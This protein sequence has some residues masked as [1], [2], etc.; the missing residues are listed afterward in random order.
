MNTNKFHVVTGRHYTLNSFRENRFVPVCYHCAK[1]G[2]I[3][4]NCF[5]LRKQQDRNFYYCSQPRITPRTKIDLTTTSD[6]KVWIKKNKK[7]VNVSF[8]TSL[9]NLADD[10]YFHSGYS[11]HTTGK[12]ENLLDY[13]H[14]KRGHF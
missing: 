7:D 13:R 5:M 14:I 11:R 10:W 2:H 6:Q 9:I 1:L 3:R 12:K 4:P 8:M